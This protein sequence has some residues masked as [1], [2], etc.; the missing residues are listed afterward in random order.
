MTIQHCEVSGI[1]SDRGNGLRRRRRIKETV[2]EID[3][4]VPLHEFTEFHQS[5]S[6][7]LKSL[8]GKQS[9][10]SIKITFF[11]SQIRMMWN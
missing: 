3:L 11:L 7:D 1:F 6:K 4:Y 2:P 10:A 9:R 8:F 5:K